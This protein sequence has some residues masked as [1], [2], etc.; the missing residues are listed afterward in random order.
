MRP[1]KA[2]DLNAPRF[3]LPVHNPLSNSF[4]DNMRVKH[5]SL[6]HLT[7]DQIKSVIKAFNG[8]IQDQV[9]N[10]RDGIQLPE[11]LGHLHIGSYKSTGPNI[12]F[13]AS[14]QYGQIIQRR[15]FHTD[16]LVAKIV[17]ANGKDKYLFKNKFLWSFSAVRQFK[18]A[19]SKFFPEQWPMYLQMDS[20]QRL[21]KSYAN[22]M[23]KIANKN[24]G[25]IP[26]NYNPFDL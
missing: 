4:C 16:G 15:N 21:N 17:Y 18:R 23:R 3:R 25:V 11:H 10:T 2:P 13:K 8:L 22:Q 26:E 24:K 7:N 6:K 14:V 9:I 1:A 5:A 20:L 19:V 12:D